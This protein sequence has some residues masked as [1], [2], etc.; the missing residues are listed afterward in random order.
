MGNLGPVVQVATLAMLDT[1]Q[2]LTLGGAITAKLVGDDHA[3]NILQVRSSLWKNRLAA[4]ALRRLC[5]GMSSTWP[6]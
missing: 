1:K 5:T 4:L 6:F 2:D 3:G